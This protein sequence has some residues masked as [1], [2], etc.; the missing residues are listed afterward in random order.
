MAR[1]VLATLNRPPPSPQ[2]HGSGSWEEPLYDAAE[3]RG[4]VPPEARTPWD[5]RAVLARVLDG[6]RFEEFKSNYGKTLVTGGGAA[7]ACMG[8][9]ISCHAQ[10]CRY[11]WWQSVG[12]ENQMSDSS[13]RTLTPIRPAPRIW[14]AVWAARGHCCKQRCAAV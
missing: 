2:Q 1:D 10:L 13:T 8:G 5:V 11:Q 14:D 12:Q 7:V 9:G 4:V 6:S 3:L